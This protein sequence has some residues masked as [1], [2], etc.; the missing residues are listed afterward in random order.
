MKILEITGV[1]IKQLSCIIYLEVIGIDIRLSSV[2]S[3][4]YTNLSI[5]TFG[6]VGMLISLNVYVRQSR[7]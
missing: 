3:K 7:K 5:L 2:N 6:R 1:E 4:N